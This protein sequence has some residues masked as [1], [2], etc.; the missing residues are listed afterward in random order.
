[1]IV[2]IGGSGF[3]GSNLASKLKK[4]KIA[5]KILDIKINKE[6]ENFTTLVNILDKKKLVRHIPLNSIIINL[7]AVHH[8]DE[9]KRDYYSV[10]VEGSKNI[11]EAALL[12]KCKKI[13]FFS[14]VSVYGL[15]KPFADENFPQNADN[16]YGKSKKKAEIVYLEWSKI[17]KNNKL[18]IIRPTAVLG[19][20]NRGNIF[21]LIHQIYKGPV[22]IVGSG[23]NIKSL[24]Y[25]ENVTDYI[26]YI[27]SLK[28]K[29]FISNYVDQPQ[30]TLK[31][32]I[33]LCNKAFNNKNNIIKIPYVIAFLFAFI[34]DLVS[35]I[36]NKKF[37]INRIRIKKLVSET[38]YQA[39]FGSFK[40]SYSLKDGLRETIKKEFG[41]F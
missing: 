10:N 39:N 27:L 14:S 37:K 32:I 1:M 5:F 24:A 34:L 12:N 36:F 15:A 20:G 2:L 13:I 35:Y 26:L 7:A 30:L 33:I 41:I 6:L 19:P 9:K 11:C 25:L 29:I 23:K 4:K 31:E 16:H 17:H 22:F 8:D 40:P 28:K 38:S 3:I 18:A 21:N